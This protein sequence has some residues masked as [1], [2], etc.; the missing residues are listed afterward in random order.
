MSIPSIQFSEDQA[1][2]FDSISDLLKRA[3]VDIENDVVLPP[4]DSKSSVMAVI[5]KAGSGKTLLLAELYRAIEAAGVEV[6]SGDYESRKS[7]DKRTLAILAPTNKAASV[8]RNRG[9]PATT[10]HRILYTPCLL[11]TSPSP[12]D[13][14]GSRMPSSA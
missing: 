8:L 4:Q 12:R 11:Y 9:V 5:G 14:R 10:I 13:Q 6:V 3:G 7:K 1:H 2:A